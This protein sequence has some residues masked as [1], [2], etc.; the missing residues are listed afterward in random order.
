MDTLI[1]IG[2][3]LLV[4]GLLGLIVVLIP[5]LF[6]FIFNLATDMDPDLDR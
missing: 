4:L 1:E 5:I 6:M 2:K 3:A